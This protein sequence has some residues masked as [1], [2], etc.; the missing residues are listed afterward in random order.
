MQGLEST[1]VSRKWKGIINHTKRLEDFKYKIHKETYGMKNKLCCL[2]QG[3]RLMTNCT[4]DRRLCDP[5]REKVFEDSDQRFSKV[6]PGSTL[7][8]LADHHYHF[9]KE[10]ETVKKYVR[11]Y[12]NPYET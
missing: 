3:K 12:G 8:V 5:C 11:D 4:C 9:D 6:W 1:G 10:C 2:V 7:N